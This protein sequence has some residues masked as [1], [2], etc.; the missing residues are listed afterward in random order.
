MAIVELIGRVE[1]ANQFSYVMPQ[2][3][4]L[5]RQRIRDLREGRVPIEQLLIRQ[6]ITR[7]ISEYLSPS[8]AALTARKLEKAGKTVGVGQHIQFV[9]SLGNPGVI[10]WV[11]S[12]N[13][14]R[15]HRYRQ[16]YFHLQFGKWHRE[17]W[18]EDISIGVNRNLFFQTAK[19]PVLS[20]GSNRV[21]PERYNRIPFCHYYEQG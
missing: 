5:L 8:P 20:S 11:R 4:H 13:R 2:I 6:R 21:D 16:H 17:H 12:P 10:P 9:F 19:S 18:K 7:E 1:S 15:I 3:I 14:E